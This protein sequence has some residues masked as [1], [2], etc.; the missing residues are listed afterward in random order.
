M[1]SFLVRINSSIRETRAEFYIGIKMIRRF[2]AERTEGSEAG[3]PDYLSFSGTISFKYFKALSV[4][5]KPIKGN[6]WVIAEINFSLSLPIFI[7][8]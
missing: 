2:T 3:S 6:D 4:L 1:N 8:A 7:F 5:G